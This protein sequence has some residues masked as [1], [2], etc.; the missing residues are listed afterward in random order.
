MAKVQIF[1]KFIYTDDFM[2]GFL[3]FWKNPWDIWSDNTWKATWMIE[4][5][6]VQ[7]IDLELMLL[8]YMLYYIDQRLP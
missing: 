7:N 6:W 4:N 3:T 2:L 8:Q 1:I 5:I